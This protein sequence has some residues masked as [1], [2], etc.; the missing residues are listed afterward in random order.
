MAFTVPKD[1]NGPIVPDP[2]KPG[3][4]C[5]CSTLVSGPDG[6]YG[7]DEGSWNDARN[8]FRRY[9]ATN[10]T[11]TGAEVLAPK[12][13]TLGSV[14][15]STAGVFVTGRPTGS[16]TGVLYRVAN[17]ALEVVGPLATDVG[18]IYPIPPYVAG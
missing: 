2:T 14:A 12:S 17:G 8:F 16:T 13:G 7:V 15:P 1:L 9:D 10:L 18:H 3:P 4:K 11:G 6:V 5:G